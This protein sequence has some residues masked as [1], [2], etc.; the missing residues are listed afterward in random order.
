MVASGFFKP[1]P[2]AHLASNNVLICVL[3]ATGD[4]THE[5]ESLFHV[6]KNETEV[7]VG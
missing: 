5:E 3:R 4:Y 6:Q 2:S 7:R 1:V